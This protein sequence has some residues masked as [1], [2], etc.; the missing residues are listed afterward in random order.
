MDNLVAKGGFVH[1][2]YPGDA[3]EG[4]ATLLLL[5]GTGGDEDA[6]VPL[7]RALA[8]RAALLSPRGRVSENG[9]SRFFRRHAPGVLDVEDLKARTYELA[10]FV[11]EAAEAHGFDPAGV[12][13][14]GYSNG[15]N[16]AASLL[17]LRPGTL[18]GAVLLRPVTPFEPEVLP[19]L[20]GVPVFV[21]GGRR[22]RMV[23]AEQSER[24]AGL[25]RDAGAEVSLRWHPGGHELGHGELEGV[26]AW[27]AS[28]WM[29]QPGRVPWEPNAERVR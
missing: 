17:L 1:R 21:A 12:V 3:G 25:L 2:F 29:P 27:L 8:P 24:L 20:A 6:L 9:M 16:I 5:H 10:G 23:P 19:D 14:V 13:G 11:G 18:A 4:S 26:Q 22:D 7:G 28:R 15:A